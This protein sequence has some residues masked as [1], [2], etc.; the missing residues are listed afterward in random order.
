MEGKRIP[1]IDALK[2]WGIFL[3]TFAHLNPCLEL[4]T[5]IYSFHM[6]LFFF[7]SGY[8]FRCNSSLK[9]FIFKKTK[10]LLV[11]FIVWNILAAFMS[12]IIEKDVHA[13]ISNFFMINGAS[14]INRPI[15]FLW[16]LFIVEVLYSVIM[17]INS[18]KWTSFAVLV[19]SLLVW[20][21]LDRCDLR[22]FTFKLNLVPFAL[23]FY[24]FGN[25]I[26]KTS[27]YSSVKKTRL[28]IVMIAVI[29][30]VASVVFG[31]MLNIRI[32]YSSGKFGNIFYCVIAAISGT[33]FYFLL[34][35]NCEFLGKVRMLCKLGENSMIIMCSQFLFFYVYDL[36]SKKLWGISVWHS[37]STL[38]ALVFSVLTMAAITMLVYIFKRVFKNNRRVLKM[39]TY[40]GVR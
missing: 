12:L 14:C 11:P 31:A 7:I 2:G 10:S 29:S 28:I 23:I 32:I 5:H 20:V 6:C 4:E 34:F 39:G 26:K 25:L 36:I 18:S 35:E 22:D 30:L 27:I 17:K 16:I 8:L 40:F 33:C 13:T 38:K 15:W 37:V 21:I 19:G 3:V 24:S 1:W 9:E